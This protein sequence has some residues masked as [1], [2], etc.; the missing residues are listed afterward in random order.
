MTGTMPMALRRW[1]LAWIALPCAL[2]LG[3]F[4]DSRVGVPLLLLLVAA[5]FHVCRAEDGPEAG[6]LSVIPALVV[7]GLLLLLTGFPS[8]PYA[9]DW[10]KHWALLN[11]LKENAWPAVIELQGEPAY[12]RF[13]IA[14]YLAPA[15]LLKILPGLPNWLVLGVWFGCGITL[16]MLGLSALR[17]SRS[18]RRALAFVGLVLMMGGADWLAQSALRWQSNILPALVPGA[19]S[20]NWWV[21]HSWQQLQ[22]TSVLPALLWVPHQSIAVFLFVLLLLSDSGRS[23]WSA[24]CLVCGLLALWSPYGLIGAIPLLAAK[25]WRER[26]DFSIPAG[27]ALASAALFAALVGYMLSHQ[28]PL[29]SMCLACGLARLSVVQDYGLFWLV[30]LGPF[31]LILRRQLWRDLYCR[32]A[33]ITALAVT[34][35]HGE[36]PDFVMRVTLAPLFVLALQSARRLSEIEWSWSPSV[37]GCAAFA[38]LMLMLPTAATEVSFHATRG[39]AHLALPQRDPQRQIWTYT[40]ADHDRYSA[41]EFFDRCGWRFRSQYFSDSAPPLSPDVK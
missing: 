31:A 17:P 34:L 24:A 18:A 10:I 27:L 13:Y 35:V 29:G 41:R 16:L 12:L 20:E 9:W 4:V 39:Q 38:A 11:T 25:W 19:H 36:S 33:V 26:P 22:L 37:A 40:F 6:R 14:A 8:G 5:C 21:N 23:A 7:A 15:G 30:E 2:F 3:F 1:V 32:V 28:A